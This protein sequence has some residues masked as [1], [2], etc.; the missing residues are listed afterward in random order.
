MYRYDKAG[1]MVGFGWV[2]GIRLAAGGCLVVTGW[3]FGGSCFCSRYARGGENQAAATSATILHDT[4]AY[5][6]WAPLCA[7]ILKRRLLDF[8]QKR[9]LHQSAAAAAAAASVA[10]AGSCHLLHDGSGAILAAASCIARSSS[11]SASSPPGLLAHL[12]TRGVFIAG[13]GLAAATVCSLLM[14]KY[15]EKMHG[16]EQA[17]QEEVS[18]DYVPHRATFLPM[19]TFGLDYGSNGALR[20]VASLMRRLGP[21]MMALA[22]RTNTSLVISVACLPV[23]MYY[24]GLVA[25]G[26]VAPEVR[27][28]PLQNL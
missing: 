17:R 2:G 20:G 10:A 13:V 16:V 18:V 1:G 25:V 5:Y 28:I 6:W 4:G 8:L 15:N 11:T 27:D 9:A 7:L 24:L 21:A 22:E 14:T 26:R 3:A 12:L 19:E 23:A